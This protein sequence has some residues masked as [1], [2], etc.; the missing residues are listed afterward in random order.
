MRGEAN[1]DIDT[2]GIDPSMRPL[3]SGMNI[4][5]K[6]AQ[7]EQELENEVISK[8][9]K[10]NFDIYIFALK[11]G[12]RGSDAKKVILDMINAGRLPKQPVNVSY[13]AWK[14]RKHVPIRYADEAQP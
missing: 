4:P 13:D 12:F 8:H 2:E 5:K 6:R 10:T 11:R 7:F 1:F 14:K 3:F 9:L